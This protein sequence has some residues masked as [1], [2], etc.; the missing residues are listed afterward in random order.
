MKYLV[1]ANGLDVKQRLIEMGVECNFIDLSF[2]KKVDEVMPFYETENP[3]YIERLRKLI[4]SYAPRKIVVIGKSE[5]YRWDGTV[6]CR[7]FG[8]FNSWLGQY[9]DAF[10]RTTLSI[11]ERPS[12]LTAIDYVEDWHYVTEGK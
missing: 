5:G 10:G 8:Q 12:E 4:E 1:L 6:V 3:E 11:L 9:D 7:V 2:G